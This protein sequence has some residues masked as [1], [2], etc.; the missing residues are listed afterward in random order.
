MKRTTVDVEGE[1][2]KA[3]LITFEAELKGDDA[4][5]QAVVTR[6]R[7]VSPEG[8]PEYLKAASEAGVDDEGAMSK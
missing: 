1:K 2:Q 7:G 6:L 3:D 4:D 8:M 5:P